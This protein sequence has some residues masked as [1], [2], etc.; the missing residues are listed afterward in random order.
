MNELPEL[1][2]EINSPAPYLPG[3]QVPWW[4]WVIAAVVVLGL[5]ALVIYLAT[6]PRPAAP[7]DLP[8]LY[9][10]YRKQLKELAGNLEGKALAQVATEASLAIRGYLSSALSEPTLFETNEETLARA[11]ALKSLPEGAREHLRPLLNKLAEYKYGPSQ[12]DPTLASELVSDC[13][14]VLKGIHSTQPR[15]IA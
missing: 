3:I 6:R 15:R 13:L 11:D 1:P 4:A 14:Q 12:T 8:S 9:G 5:I 7:P 2:H 10:R